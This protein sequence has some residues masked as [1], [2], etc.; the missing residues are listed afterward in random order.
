MGNVRINIKVV[1]G[2]FF[3]LALIFDLSWK[4]LIATLIISFF[5]AWFNQRQPQ[6]SSHT[7]HQTIV[8]SMHS[9]FLPKL[10]K[11]LEISYKDA[12]Q[13]INQITLRF[14]TLSQLVKKRN[15]IDLC[16]AAQSS[17]ETAGHEKQ[18]LEKEMN[19]AY[20]ELMELLQHGDRNLQRQAGVMELL[21]LIV[22][23]LQAIDD[24][25]QGWDET[26]LN[27][28]LN[29]IIDRTELAIAKE[30]SRNESDEGVT[31]F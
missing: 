9:H 16:L 20:S 17:D 6:S 29:R 7:S 4:T 3:T 24:E 14:V 19:V 10:N 15:E 28:Q 5:T 13:S 21:A 11:Q 1:F 27:N 12:H 8:H 22:E 25:G 23:E 18:K 31:Y 2:V 30:I 26:L